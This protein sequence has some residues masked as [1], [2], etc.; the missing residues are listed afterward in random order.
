MTE[1]NQDERRN[2]GRPRSVESHQAILDATLEMLAEEGFQGASIEGIAA[3]AGVGKTTIY[4]RWSTK[5]E[6]IADALGELH[7]H[8]HFIDTGHFRADLLSSLREIQQHLDGHPLMRS[9]FLRLFGEAQARPEFMQIFYNQVFAPR[10][11]NVI[12]FFAQAQARGELRQDLEPFFIASLV[13]GPLL[14][15]LLVGALLPMPYNSQRLPERILD[16]V[17]Q[18]IGTPGN[19]SGA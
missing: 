18:G 12:R 2:V 11:T 19:G 7:I 9:L 14:H 3:R 10:I 5:D 17:L 13:L 4:R 1:E 8:L 6:L 15:N 16:A